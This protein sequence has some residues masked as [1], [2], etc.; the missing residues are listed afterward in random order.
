MSRRTLSFLLFAVAA[1]AVC[2]RLGV[3]Q[4]SRRAERREANARIASRLVAPPEPFVRVAPLGDSARF[5][6]VHLVGVADYAHEQV[7]GARTN[8]G[9]PGVHLLTPLRVGGRDTVVLV[10]RGWVYSPDGASV[11]RARWREGDTLAVT[12]FV[13]RY[14]QGAARAHM[15]T[16]GGVTVLRT[17]DRAAVAAAVGA[18]LAPVLVVATQLESR[19]AR[20]AETPVRLTAPALDAGPHLGY[21]IQWFAFATIA[22]VGSAVVW[23]RSRRPLAAVPAEGRGPRA[24]GRALTSER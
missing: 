18:P 8:G 19:P 24:E 17:L 15:G 2:V 14:A 1:A 12:G 11:D 3:W 6:R 5:R 10:N 23:S 22:L 21:A 4:L 20:A 9:S 13:E 7:L 16:R